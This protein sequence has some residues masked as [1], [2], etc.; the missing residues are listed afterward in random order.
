MNSS[1]H[2]KKTLVCP[3]GGQPQIISM[4]LDLLLARGESIEQV[5]VL[6]LVANP[7]YRAS[8]ERLAAEFSGEYYLGQ[9]CQLRGIPIR[10]ATYDFEHVRNP[11]EVDS[12]WQ[13]FHETLGS[14]KSDG[15]QVHLSLSAG[16]RIFS[17]LALSA[18]MLHFTTADRAWHIYTP[19]DAL[20]QAR[21][22][23]LMHLAPDAGV[24]L[25]EVPLVPWVTLFPGLRGV[26]ERSPG[27]LRSGRLFWLDEVTRAQ[28]RQVWQML[29]PRQRASLQVLCEHENRERA[30]QA[31]GVSIGT[32]DDHKTDILRYCRQVW[33]DESAQFNLAFLRRHFRP[34]LAEEGSVGAFDE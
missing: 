29:S 3:L 9:R 6:Y 13:A 19:P 8:F 1:S 20:E 26:M 28:C 31:L 24:H 25:I 18:A 32:L 4:T 2:L 14:L 5:F 22:G 12:V 33:D 11:I 27:Q 10:C 23:R 17:L 16:P 34:F 30:A 21:D 15:Q 7:R